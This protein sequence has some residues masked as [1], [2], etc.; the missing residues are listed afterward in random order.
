MQ[1]VILKAIITKHLPATEHRQAR[2]KASAYGM[3]GYTLNYDFTK[4]PEE[5]HK[6]AAAAFCNFYGWNYS[7]YQGAIAEGCA[8]VCVK[9]TVK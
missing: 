9:K 5:N 6:D 4:S 8:F 2:I 1:E 3:P 7:L